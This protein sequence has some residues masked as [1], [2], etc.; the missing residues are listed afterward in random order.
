MSL[1]IASVTPTLCRL[2]RVAPPS[3]C[4]EKPIGLHEGIAAPAQVSRALVFVADAIGT[5][6]LRSDEDAFTPVISHAPMRIEVLSVMPSITP[7]CMASMFTG[8]MP[9]VHGNRN[10]E[11]RV[12][13]CD[14]IFDAFARAGKKIAVASVQ[15]SSIDLIFR[16]HP[17][18]SFPENDDSKAAQRAHALLDKDEHDLILVYQQEYDDCMH[19]TKPRSPE[20]LRALHRHI[21]AF[22]AL[23]SAARGRWAGSLHAIAFLSDHGVHVDPETGRGN[24]GSDLP[25][26]LE[27]THFWGL[28]R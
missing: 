6:L 19:A 4:T 7:V 24:H 22:D 13:S 14:T 28:H 20:A 9:E 8:A 23:A 10:T 1:T 12:L 18:D 27:V 11:R 25:E 2:F 16:N 21:E 3:V 15:G 17:L 26:D 5:H